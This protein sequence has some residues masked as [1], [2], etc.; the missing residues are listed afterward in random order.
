MKIVPKQEKTSY[1]VMSCIKRYLSHMNAPCMPMLMCN[2]SM[3]PIIEDEIT[4]PYC[5]SPLDV[6]KAFSGTDI[7]VI[8]KEMADEKI[9]EYEIENSRPIISYVDSFSCNWMTYYKKIHAD[10][11]VM[12]IGEYKDAYYVLD[13]YLNGMV[14]CVCK[15]VVRKD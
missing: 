1:C 6:L 7:R 5:T 14:N 11:F 8:T 15:E 4:L 12:I 2:W 13:P 9:I 10:H 3:G